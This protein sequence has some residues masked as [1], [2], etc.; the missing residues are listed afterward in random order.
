MY[1]PFFMYR[2][3]SLF[4]YTRVRRHILSQ[5]RSG[6]THLLAKRADTPRGDQRICTGQTVF[7]AEINQLQ[8]S[9]GIFA[10]LTCRE[11]KLQRLK[12]G[13]RQHSFRLFKI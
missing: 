12:S 10:L 9:S 4:Q 5:P 11:Y 7:S 2:C 1:H 6:N 13:F 8:V 3:V